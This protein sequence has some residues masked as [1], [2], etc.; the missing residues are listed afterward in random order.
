MTSTNSS[1]QIPQPSYRPL[2]HLPSTPQRNP[3]L[4]RQG[5][6][7][8]TKKKNLIHKKQAQLERDYYKQNTKLA[9]EQKEIAHYSFD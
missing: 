5:N 7:N 1:N 2:R 3:I 8:P 9:K 6:Q 4:P